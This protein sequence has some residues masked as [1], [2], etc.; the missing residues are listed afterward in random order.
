MTKSKKS[1][2]NKK[3]IIIGSVVGVVVILLLIAFFSITGSATTVAFLNV[4]AGEVQVDLGKGWLPATDGMELSLND[5][6]KTSE[7]GEASVVLYESAIISL[8]S[9]TE[10]T[11][12]DLSKDSAVIKQDSGST[13]N[14]FTGLSGLKGL[15]VETPNT[16]ATVRG[17]EYGVDM[18]GV[19]VMEGTVDAKNKHNGNILKVGA[20]KSAMLV[21]KELK[22]EQMSDEQKIRLIKKME[23]NVVRMK[24]LRDREMQKHPRI[25]S[26]VKKRLKIDDAGLKERIEKLDEGRYDED[27]LVEKSP[28]RVKSIEKFAELTKRI[29]SQ[30]EAILKIRETMGA[31]EMPPD[32][33]E[34]PGIGSEDSGLLEEDISMVDPKEEII[35]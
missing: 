31:P 17:T 4:E 19:H 8:D 24:A 16:V 9:G 10:I 23:R 11:L 35:K 28:V 6:I 13:W 34:N 21:G 30:K 26:M 32:P 27:A 33:L 5:K 12:E 1:K 14:K 22:L 20:G 2:Y 29:K 15:E 18:N 7:D 25:V 3:G